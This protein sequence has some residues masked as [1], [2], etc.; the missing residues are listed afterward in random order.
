[1]NKINKFFKERVL[2]IKKMNSDKSFRELTMKW[3]K[4]SIK[5]KYVYNFTWMGRPI[6]KYPNDMIVMQEIFWEVKPDLVIETGIAHGGSI[7]YSASLLKMMGIKRFKVI[8]IDIDIRA[9]NLKEI[10]EAQCENI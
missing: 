9:H 5:Y 3:I 4:K 2:D 7:I 10:N 1:M 6:I 8:G